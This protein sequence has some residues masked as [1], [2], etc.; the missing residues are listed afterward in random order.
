MYGIFTYIWLI[1]MVNVGE[2]AMHG[3]YGL[4]GEGETYRELVTTSHSP[5]ILT[6][7]PSDLSIFVGFL[8]RWISLPWKETGKHNWTQYSIGSQTKAHAKESTW[9][10][11]LQESGQTHI[12][13]AL[14]M[15][16]GY[17]H[18]LNPGNWRIWGGANRCWFHAEISRTS[19]FF[20]KIE[21]AK[22]PFFVV[23]QIRWENMVNCLSSKLPTILTH[24][25]R[26]QVGSLSHYLT[27]FYNHPK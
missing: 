15:I 21:T 6:V 25:L 22:P 2:Y 4:G 20:L 10:T 19:W 13:L 9:E 17:V 8:S 1:F 24:Q 27:G 11:S 14:W 12:S 16:Q 3:S 18:L 5:F 7:D 26:V 23:Q